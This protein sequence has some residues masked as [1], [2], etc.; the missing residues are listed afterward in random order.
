MNC[1][2][3]VE[4]RSLWRRLHFGA[5]RQ[6]EDFGRLGG[7]CGCVWRERGQVGTA[8]LEGEGSRYYTKM[9]CVLMCTLYYKEAL[10]SCPRNILVWTLRRSSW[11]RIWSL[12]GVLRPAG[13]LRF[14]PLALF[15]PRC[16]FYKQKS[17]VTFYLNLQAEA[18]SSCLHIRFPSQNN[19]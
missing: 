8:D 7:R 4:K 13:P 5:H 10:F 19:S 16:H 2:W 9:A 17:P 18:V 11:F 6:R 14:C 12:T 1:T 3:K 15:L